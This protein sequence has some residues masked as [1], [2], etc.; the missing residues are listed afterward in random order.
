[1]FLLLFLSIIY[2]IYAIY[3][4]L[5]NKK[6][7]EKMKKYLFTGL[8]AVL[9]LSGAAVTSS[10][11]LG[12]NV[13]DVDDSE[14][15]R[16]I[17]EVSK[18]LNGLSEEEV[19]QSQNKVFNSI[20]TN[21]TKNVELVDRYHVLNNAILIDIS[22]DKVDEIK[23]LDGV[24]S[25]DIDKIRFKKSTDQNITLSTAGI[26]ASTTEITPKSEQDKGSEGENIT[27]TTLRKPSG[28]ADGE[29]T[30]IAVLDN[31]FY[32]KGKTATEDAWSH[33][34]YKPLPAGTIQKFDHATVK[35]KARSGNLH[36]SAGFNASAAKGSEGSLYFNSKVP[37][38]Y[39]YGGTAPTYGGDG[40]PDCDV[41]STFTY[42]GTHVSSLIGGNANEYK[43]L[44][45]KCQLVCMKVFTEFV[46]DETAKSLGFSNSSGGRDSAILNALEDCITLG[47]D[48]I[49][50]SLG[51]DLDDFDQDTLCMRTISRLAKDAGIMTAIA[52]GNGGKGSFGFTGGYGAWT[53]D[54]VETGVLGSYANCY[55]ATIVASAQPDEVYYENAVK[56]EDAAGN[57]TNIAYQDQIVNREGY[58]DDYPED[59]QMY[60]KDCAGANGK[61]EW[62]YIPNFGTSSDYKGKEVKGKIAIVNRGSTSFVDKYNV[63]VS[64]GAIGLMIINN[65]PTSNEFNFRCSFGDGFSPT[66]PAALVLYKDKV[67]IEN[68]G[69]GTF[70]FIQKQ[71]SLN[72][73]GKTVSS[74]TND[75]ARFTYDIKPDVAAP[76]E[77]IKGAI[78]PQKKEDKQYNSISTYEYLS[79]TSMATPNYAGAQALLL[80]EKAKVVFDENNDT[81]S[82]DIAAYNDYRRTVDMRLMS[83]ANAMKDAKANPETNQVSPT[84]PRIQGA[85]LID[86]T[87]AIN[88]KVYL[89]GLDVEGNE[90]DK[91]KIQL[92][93]NDDIANGKLKMTFNA[94]NED[95]AN[96]SFKVK[97]TVMRPALERNN[98]VVQDKYNYTGEVDD[99]SKLGGFTYWKQQYVVGTG[100]VPTKYTS[101]GTAAQYD[102]VKLTKQIEYYKTEE[103]CANETNK[104][105]I[106][107]GYY[108]NAAESGFD[109]QPLPDYTYQS[110]SDVVLFE[111]ET[112]QTVTLQPGKNV[113]N[114]DE[115]NLPD[116]EKNKIA[117]AFE[118]GCAIEGYVEL[119]A[120]DAADPDLSIP[121]LGFYSLAD[122]KNGQTLR[123]ARVAEPF[124]FEKVEGVSYP[125]DLVNDVTKSLLGK[126]NSDMGS[127]WVTGYADE[128]TDIDTSKVFHCETSFDKLTGFKSVGK[129]PSTG[130]YY[131]SAK[132]CIY[133]GSPK[134]TNT[135]IIQQFMM[136]S[137]ADNNFKIKDSNGN[138]VYA[139]TLEDSLFGDTEGKWTLY[140]SHVDS[141]LLGSGY[142]AHRAFAIV[143]LYD[144]NTKVPFADGE[145]TIEFNYQLSYDESWVSTSYKFVVDATLPTISSINSYEKDGETRIRINID[146]YKV[147]AAVVGY[148]NETVYY[149]AETKQYY[150]DL[151]KADLEASLKDLGDVTATLSTARPRLYLELT[152]GA[153][154]VNK[155]I[156]HFNGDNYNEYEIVTGDVLDVTYDFKYN[157]STNSLEWVAISYDG[158]ETPIELEG[159]SYKCN[160]KNT[161]STQKGEGGSI[162]DGEKGCSASLASS[163]ALILLATTLGLALLL[164][165][166]KAFGGIR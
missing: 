122:K 143:P 112:G 10:D 53:T 9:A 133:V 60:L 114:I 32:L 36:A 128:V 40:V 83:T 51:S 61:V 154:G 99:I 1:M 22:A 125:S 116:L 150:L 37:F 145:Y 137:V 105:I 59:K 139:S 39:D 11:T 57:V 8:M 69:E 144:I 42:H 93:N 140:K 130:S 166:R 77:S 52:A 78:P 16:V 161:T 106:P 6:K 121:F 70:E 62:V 46:A 64:N 34:T 90:I 4:F 135:M 18:G 48:G 72:A 43:G 123:D 41:I 155:M 31:E 160:F 44:A 132:D 45:P 3:F 33:A 71:A 56:F 111:G 19:T 15:V 158:E 164:K 13:S 82:E 14:R 73:N 101:Q 134:V 146:D 110:I 103:D 50:M 25:V 24:G 98:K 35:S 124:E 117:D 136:R 151:S 47:V 131:D 138:V 92:R 113:V 68:Q 76:G 30:V 84:S 79:G 38:Y 87:D 65:D 28:T 63:A 85:G 153:Y 165:K 148:G 54:T 126:N 142:V 163:S 26:L 55:D 17:V 100:Y 96:K 108:Y 95:S 119:I 118:F 156:I 49:N 159:V 147:S 66:I 102:C 81:G 20:K 7:G 86:L 5:C 104:Q 157:E 91:S 58:D 21:I 109:W 88:T 12:V 67:I 120:V 107:T 29:G 80:G 89:N 129:D 75:G 97:L 27:A 127:M 115:W 141:N 149:D 152:D 2:I 74:F 94:Y 162:V 23:K